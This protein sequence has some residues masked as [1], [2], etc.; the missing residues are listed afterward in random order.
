MRNGTA[1]LCAI[2]DARVG[3]EIQVKDTA[4]REEEGELAEGNEG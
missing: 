2:C 4:G 1:R 3:E